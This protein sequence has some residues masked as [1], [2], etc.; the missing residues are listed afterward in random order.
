MD[1]EV[2]EWLLAEMTSQQETGATHEIVAALEE[3]PKVRMKNSNYY[4]G[5]GW[6]ND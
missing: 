1:A 3:N 5:V 4:F 2:I 6:E